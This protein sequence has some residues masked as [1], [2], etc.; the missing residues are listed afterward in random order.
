MSVADI[1]AEAEFDE[2][3]LTVRVVTNYASRSAHI[4]DRSIEIDSM[5]LLQKQMMEK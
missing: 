3:S 5:Q 1:M 2:R 4:Y